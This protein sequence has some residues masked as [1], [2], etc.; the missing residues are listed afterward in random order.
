MEADLGEIR[1]KGPLLNHPILCTVI[2]DF[3]K[4]NHSWVEKKGSKGNNSIYRAMFNINFNQR[5]NACDEFT[6]QTCAYPK[7]SQ[8]PD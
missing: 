2:W 8:G 1:N 5:H 7:E 3:I 6:D 4:G